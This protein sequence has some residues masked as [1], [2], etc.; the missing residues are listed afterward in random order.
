MLKERWQQEA[1]R[2]RERQLPG[3]EATPVH[4]AFLK[5]QREGRLP[6]EVFEAG[7]TMEKGGLKAQAWRL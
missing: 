5:L 2:E 3:R 4:Q 6:G 1:R 7:R